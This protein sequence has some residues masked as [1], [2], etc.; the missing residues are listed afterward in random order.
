MTIV[1]LMFTK[2]NGLVGSPKG[3][4]LTNPAIRALLRPTKAGL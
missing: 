1:R 3:N 2:Q 4:V